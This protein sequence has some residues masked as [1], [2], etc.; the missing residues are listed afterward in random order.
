VLAFALTG[1]T[2]DPPAPKQTITGRV[3]SCWDSQRWLDVLAPDGRL[4][5]LNVLGGMPTC[6]NFANG[7]NWEVVYH[8]SIAGTVEVDSIRLIRQ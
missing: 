3:T 2:P 5:H 1:C 6:G 4:V 8:D 7:G